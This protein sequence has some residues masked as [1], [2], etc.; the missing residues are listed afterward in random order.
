MGF[1]FFYDLKL[2]EQLYGIMLFMV[3]IVHIVKKKTGEVSP[4]FLSDISPALREK[5]VYEWGPG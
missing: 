5:T 1:S 4:A 2:F 3:N